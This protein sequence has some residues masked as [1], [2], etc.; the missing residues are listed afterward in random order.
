[1]VTDFYVEHEPVQLRFRQR[2]SSLL[3][4]RVLRRDREKRWLQI[5]RLVTDGDLAFLHRLQK[6]RLSFR[7]RS[8]DL[9]GQ[10]NIGEDWTFDEAELSSAV[11][12]FVE[13]LSL[14]HI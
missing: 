12:V 5:I 9:I 1:M 11:F 13:N 7:W 2:V 8:V 10:Q 14:I 4:D 6:G 3:L